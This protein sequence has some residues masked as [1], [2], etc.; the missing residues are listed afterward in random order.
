MKVIMKYDGKKYKYVW[1][2]TD[3]GCPDCAFKGKPE[4]DKAP[5]SDGHWVEIEEVE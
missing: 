3:I 4:C 2:Y 5:C 1:D